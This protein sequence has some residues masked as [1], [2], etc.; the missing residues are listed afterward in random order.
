[1][2]RVDEFVEALA[3][4]DWEALGPLLDASH[5]SLRDDYEV[6]CVELDAAVETARQAGALGARMTG[7]GFGGSVIA[8]VPRR[9]GRGGAGG[10]RDGVRRAGV[11]APG[12]LRRR[13]RS[14]RPGG[15]V[16]T[17]AWLSESSSGMI[18]GPRR[19][20][21]RS[22]PGSSRGRS[23]PVLDVPGPLANAG[24]RSGGH[25]PRSTEEA[26]ARTAIGVAALTGWWPRRCRRPH[27]AGGRHSGDESARVGVY[28]SGLDEPFGLA[29]TGRKGFVVAE[30]PRGKVT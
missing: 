17:D 3:T 16:A 15:R 13:T 27:G 1:M 6:S 9:A 11:G 23:I 12:L 25:I 14:G 2:A 10:G 8:L 18:S 30:N 19:R 21:V 7:G 26:Y 22:P 28:A 20:I 4:D 5:A 24:A 29:T